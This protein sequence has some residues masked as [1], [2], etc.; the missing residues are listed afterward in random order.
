MGGLGYGVYLIHE[1]V[2]RLLDSLG[3]LAEA[4]PGMTFLVSA[5]LVAVPTGLL[6]WLS[7][8]TIE[9]AGPKLLAT[10]DGS[11]NARDY[12]PYVD[13]SRASSGRE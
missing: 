11:G 9:T 1:P 7:S 6:A 10:I 12:Y 3:V 4:A 2:L 13:D 5:A 8:R